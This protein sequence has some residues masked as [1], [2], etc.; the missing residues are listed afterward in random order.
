M[1]ATHF[2]FALMQTNAGLT[3]C[4]SCDTAIEMH[5]PGATL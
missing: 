5:S 3:P 1:Y 4:V 2:L